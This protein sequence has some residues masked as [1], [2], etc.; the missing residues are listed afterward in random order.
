MRKD[1]FTEEALAA[2]RA[3]AELKYSESEEER[4]AFAEAYDFTRCQRPDGS[5]YGIGA[6]KQCRQGTP[7]GPK[8]E[9]TKSGYQPFPT[10]KVDKKIAKT[11][12]EVA[13][14]QLKE[15]WAPSDD[16]AKDREKIEKLAKRIEA[17]LKTRTSPNKEASARTRKAQQNLIRD[18]KKAAKERDRI[19]EEK[20]KVQEQLDAENE[21][22]ALANIKKYGRR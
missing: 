21:A 11:A 16:P 3:L 8:Q 6:G 17:L 18:A 5:V 2:A 7:A 9:K 4:L 1:Y 19:R 13:K 10:G 20:I 22:K 12:L 14:A 15:T